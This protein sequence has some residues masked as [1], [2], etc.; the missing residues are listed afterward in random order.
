MCAGS[1]SFADASGPAYGLL[2]DRFAAGWQ[3]R[4]ASRDE[5]DAL[6]IAALKIDR[7]ADSAAQL[8]RRAARYGGDE[9]LRLEIARDAR[10]RKEAKGASR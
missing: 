9:L 8:G 5:R 10:L 1:S 7:A 4:L 3:R 2:L 6:L